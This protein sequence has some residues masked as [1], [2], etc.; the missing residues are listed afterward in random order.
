[1]EVNTLYRN[2]YPVLDINLD[3][4]SANARIIN[5][6][7]QKNGI[8]VSGV[9]KGAGG[10]LKIAE[11]MVNAGCKH[12][13][14]SRIEQLMDVKKHYP[15]FET[16]LLR[17]PMSSE[18]EEVVKYV[19]ISLNSE[20][21]TIKALNKACSKLGKRH[22]VVLMLDLGDLR[23]GF[24]NPKELIEAAIYIENSM[25]SIE[26][27]GVGSNLGCYGSVKPTIKN[28]TL[29]ANTAKEIEKIIDRKLEIVSG[30]A[31][32]SLPLLINGEL[33]NGINNL[34]IGEGILINMD[35]PLL[36]NINIDGTHQDCF[37]FTA[38]IIEIKE[39]PSH[40]I[41]E[42]FVD[43]FGYAPVYEDKGIRKRALLAAGAQDFAMYDKLI[44]MDACI[45]MVGS[46]S[47]HLIIDITDCTKEYKLGD[48]I[49]FKVFYGPMVFLSNSKY[50][51][52][53][54]VKE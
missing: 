38:Q 4:I 23:E 12:I 50:V 51:R 1:M 27:A 32:T 13:A 40:P 6:I 2:S 42:L 29:L 11:Q 18:V 25:K 52:K 17:L 3:K 35:L 22:R 16:M 19:D 39:K 28:L 34:R 41:G 48:L 8:T 30:G 10:N 15:T 53:R 33:P 37:V 45:K 31:T 26:L 47:D 5:E 36:W 9:I 46:S 44:P 20:L 24:I 7:C 14:S 54:I 43:A 49:S 21:D